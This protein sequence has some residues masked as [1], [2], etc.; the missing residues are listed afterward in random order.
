MASNGAP[1][2]MPVRVL[3]STNTM[4]PACSA[5][6]SSSPM[7]HRTFRSRIRYPR[8]RRART[9]ASSPIAPS[10]LRLIMRHLYYDSR[11]DALAQL[12][13]LTEDSDAGASHLTSCRVCCI[14]Y[15]LLRLISANIL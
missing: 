11:E 8:R 5:T 14:L 7:G 13:H 10:C 12:G 15:L 6:R 4:C 2:S 9:A 1:Y 3:T